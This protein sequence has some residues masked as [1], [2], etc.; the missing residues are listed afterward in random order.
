MLEYFRFRREL[1]NLH[2]SRSSLTRKITDL[3]EKRTD[4]YESQPEIDW[5]IQQEDKL[6]HRIL[7]LQTNYFRGQLERHLIPMPSKG[8]S[9]YWFKYDFDGGDG[10]VYILNEGGIRLAKNLLRE[11]ER[12]FRNRVTFWVSIVF[13]LIGVITGLV[14]LLVG[15]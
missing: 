15:K 11:E 9:E 5:H 13:G 7:L 3:E 2:A 8:D 12:L 1:K 6:D 10:E 14:S 4:Y